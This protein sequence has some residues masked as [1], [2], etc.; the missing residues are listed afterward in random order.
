MEGVSEEQANKAKA[1]GETPWWISTDES[2]PIGS[3]GLSKFTNLSIE[4][5]NS[6]LKEALLSEM[7]LL[8]NLRHLA[9]NP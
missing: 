1:K 6:F 7:V 3:T 2:L 5:R 9:L 8:R 4:D